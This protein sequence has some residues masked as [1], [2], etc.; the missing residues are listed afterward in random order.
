LDSWLAL[1]NLNADV[2]QAFQIPNDAHRSPWARRLLRSASRLSEDDARRM[3]PA[4]LASRAL[5]VLAEPSRYAKVAAGHEDFAFPETRRLVQSAPH[6]PDV[7]HLHSLHG[8]FFDIRALPEIASQAPAIIT[9][10]DAWLLTGHC[11]Q[12]LDCERWRTGCGDCPRLDLY[13]P[14]PRDASAANRR[15]KREALMGSNAGLA[16][17]SR[18][19]MRMVEA[20]GLAEAPIDARVVPNGVDTRVFS[21]GD[22]AH[23][24]AELGLPMDRTIVAFAARSPED[25][26]FKDFATL[27]AAL[28]AVAADGDAD[29]ILLLALG[30]RREVT[31]LGAA[32]VRMVPFVDDPARMARFYRAADLYVHAARAENFPLTVLEAMACGTPVVASDVGGIPEIVVDGECGLLARPGD[33]HDLAAR[34][35]DLLA[36]EPLRA[37]FSASGLERVRSRFTLDRQADTYLAWYAELIEERARR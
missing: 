26:P 30:G 29:G 32:E 33:P 24:R 25:N 21:P 11:A 17:P 4:W 16:T 6:F 36:S 37:A 22:K 10:H 19:L 7:V 9:M 31:H 34:I 13:V 18:W 28:E 27:T 1:G 2:P 23:A 5:R 8:S 3:S 15:V 14:I 12:P 20:S 35:R